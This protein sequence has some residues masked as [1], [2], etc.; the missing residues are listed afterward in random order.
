MIAL[1]VDNGP[2]DAAWNAMAAKPERYAPLIRRLAGYFLMCGADEDDR[3]FPLV[4][5]L[6]E[7]AIPGYTDLTSDEA[8]FVWCGA[9]NVVCHHDPG[10]ALDAMAT[11]WM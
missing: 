6:V 5:T 3:D 11:A 9:V 1:A 7:Q 4:G 10:A 8:Y 2:T